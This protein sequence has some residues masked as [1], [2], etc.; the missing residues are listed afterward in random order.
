[1]RE[2]ERDGNGSNTSSCSEVSYC[3]FAEVTVVV[4]VAFD[5]RGSISLSRLTHRKCRKFQALVFVCLFV[6]LFSSSPTPRPPCCLAF[7]GNLKNLS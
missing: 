2:R 6:C 3:C 1:M 5:R 4:V 7:R